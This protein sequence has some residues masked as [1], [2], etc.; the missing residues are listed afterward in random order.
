LAVAP[1]DAHVRVRIV[2]IER[3]QLVVDEVG[4][5]EPVG[6]LR[7]DFAPLVARREELRLLRD[8]AIERTLEETATVE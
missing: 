8:R 7:D 6:R 3:D 5:L 4:A 1:E 2:E